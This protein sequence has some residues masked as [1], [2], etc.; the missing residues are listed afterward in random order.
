MV[1]LNN[2]FFSELQRNESRY[3]KEKLYFFENI[4]PRICD[5]VNRGI[6]DEIKIN[7]VENPMDEP[8][9]FDIVKKT[10]S[11]NI[12]DFFGVIYKDQEFY[13]RIKV[14]Y[15]ES[16]EIIKQELEEN[17]KELIPL[18]TDKKFKYLQES[19]SEFFERLNFMYIKGGER[20]FRAN[21]RFNDLFGIIKRD[22]VVRG[23]SYT[24]DD[25]IDDNGNITRYF[26]D[27]CKCN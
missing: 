22:K 24:I 12:T 4:L 7:L 3:V 20:A 23:T 5:L 18:L 26:Y 2:N 1:I 8:D 13:S 10:G 27:C 15:N 14:T 9:W 17:W 16:G 6:V 21:G 11:D 19:L 25:I